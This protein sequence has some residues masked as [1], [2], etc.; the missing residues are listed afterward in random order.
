M[1]FPP[2]GLSLC[3]DKLGMIGNT[4]FGLSLSKPGGAA[5]FSLDAPLRQRAVRVGAAA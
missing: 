2:F 5:P 4:P 1:R 3:F